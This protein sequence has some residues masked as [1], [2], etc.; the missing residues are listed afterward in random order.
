MRGG[1]VVFLPMNAVDEFG[2]T[3]YSQVAF[4]PE[5]S[6][7]T[8]FRLGDVLVAKITPCFENGKGCCVTELPTEIG[9]ASTE[10]HVLRPTAHV[11]SRY[12]WRLTTLPE[13]RTAGVS[14]MTGSAGQQRVS[15]NFVANFVV[16]LP[17]RKEQD[18]IARVVDGVDSRLRGIIN[19]KIRLAELVEERWRAVVWRAM[20][21]GLDA[22]VRLR[23]SK[24]PWIGD[25]PVHWEVRR[26]KQCARLVMG[27]SPP[28]HECGP[29][30]GRPFLQG[31]AE[32]GERHPLPDQSCQRPAKV[33][34]Q[35]S[36][37]LSVRAPVGRVNRADTEYG[38]GRGLCAVIPSER[39]LR[40][41]FAYYQL[42]A[43]QGGLLASA[44][45]ST[46]DAVTVGDIGN[47]AFLLPPK[48]EQA[49]I[50]RRLQTATADIDA[51]RAGVWREIEL[52][53]EYR[54]RLIADVVTGR[55][56]VREAAGQPADA[57]RGGGLVKQMDSALV[58]YL[59]GHPA[60]TEWLEFKGGGAA[61]ERIGQYLSALS[62]SAC[63]LRRSAGYL[64]FGVA[65]G[66][67]EVKG[68][69][70]D[71][72]QKKAKGNQALLPWIHAGMQPDPGFDAGIVE[73]PG[74]RVVVFRVGPAKDQPV[75]FRGTAYI[76][77]GS[78]TTELLRH[79]RM[80]REIWNTGTDW[81]SEPCEGATLEDLD[82][83]AV[84]AARRGFAARHPA[85][86]A[87]VT[88]WDDATFLGKAW[89]LDRGTVTNTA[90]LL[91]GRSE[92]GR[93]LRPPAV[94]QVSWILKD[95]D[96][97]PLDSE[98]LHPPL[99]FAADRVLKRIRNLTLR[100]L[101]N[102]TG[103]AMPVAQYD[104]WVLR[105]ALHNAI[106]H[107]DYRRAGRIVVTEF[108]DRVEFANLGPFLPGDVHA[109]IRQN[110][111]HSYR[112]P[113]L[114]QAMVR[115]NLIETQGG[116]IR[117]M[118]ETQKKRSFALPDYDLSRP[119]EVRVE[120]PGRIIVEDY[121]RTLFDRPDLPL[122]DA[123]LLDR[124][125]KGLPIDEESRQRLSAEGL[126]TDFGPGPQ[127]ARAS[128][129]GDRASAAADRAR[130][131]SR[132]LALVRGRGPIDRRE[133]DRAMTAYLPGGLSEERQR[134]LTQNLI[135]ELRRTGRIVNRGS[136]KK[137]LW[138][139]AE[140][141]L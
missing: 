121:N 58:D 75:S 79:P 4:P 1:D 52:L 18:T 88:E 117:R 16:R 84:A 118:F 138:T 99:L 56:D 51:A 37:L 19:D 57:K 5:G 86:A 92:A 105:E 135:Q 69:A 30:P 140:P 93:L 115:L 64:V 62:N 31:C 24:V 101:P 132:L 26:L 66:T 46:Y 25:I 123:V 27:Q 126:I 71:P 44:T 82:P 91:L 29:L 97:K 96:G 107:Q 90:V 39:D 103:A 134:I 124:V 113:F 109:V 81:S 104:E 9:L 68:T 80:A 139:V 67:H 72:H 114:G 6:P 11:D 42:E 61:P 120:I 78:H 17:T 94:S 89:V 128:G 73:H 28:G 48:A 74:G 129:T 108:P 133:I 47:H 111:P 87:A 106:A 3:R 70:F 125:Q 15:A 110:A 33:A 2:R 83:E 21:R 65:D 119:D 130:Q 36:I 63:L 77:V 49:E 54:A 122:E 116:G 35:G 14:S 98:H 127:V 10:F 85:Q 137:P 55:L 131:R 41:D 23:A 100:F 34:P 13:F 136:R 40:T 22:G 43:L 20:T 102:G 60:E 12:L 8:R 76:R 38:I 53:K 59:R 50:V 7:L 141:G 112:N 95:G 32:F 45:G